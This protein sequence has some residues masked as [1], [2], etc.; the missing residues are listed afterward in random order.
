[1]R[2][3]LTIRSV[4]VFALAAVALLA[5]SCGPARKIAVAGVDEPYFN[6]LSSV[7]TRAVVA[8]GS[9]KDF[10]VESATLRFSYKGRELASARLMLPVEVPARSDGSVRV[11]L[12]LESASLSNLQTLQR[13]AQ[14]NPSQ[15][16]VSVRA[17]VRFGRAVRDVEIGDAPYSA[18]I[19]NFGPIIG[20]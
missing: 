16:T 13:R 9:A 19:A 2:R 7:H 8:N 15:L 14:T 17:R 20:Q 1:M 6:G 4:A 10:V 3:P 5:V 11:D 12:K 18:I